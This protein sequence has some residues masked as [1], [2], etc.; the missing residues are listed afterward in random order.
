MTLRISTPALRT[1]LALTALCA[2]PAL[3]AASPATSDT[4]TAAPAAASMFSAS[5]S[6]ADVTREFRYQPAGVSSSSDDLDAADPAA[7]LNEDSGAGQPPPGRRRTYGRSRYQDRMHNADGSSKIAFMAGAGMNI[8]NGN[9]A[10]FYTPSYTF[11]VG[12]GLNFNRMFGVLAEFHYDRMGVTGGAINTEYNNLLNYL[13]QYGYTANDLAGFDANAHVL[14]FT[15]NPVI[16]FADRNSHV[17]AYVT[18]GL[19]Y[20]RKS[21][22]FTLPTAQTGCSYYYCSTY[23]TTYDFDSATANS[24][25]YNVGFGLTYKISEFSNERLFVDARYNWVPIS[26]NNNQDF[27]PYNRRHTSF[28]PVTV[29]IRF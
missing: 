24:I 26:S 23:Y 11:G 20:Y 5:A 9:T 3:Y 25:G 27:F 7:S 10:K 13:S 18:G 22:N 8:P 19:G 17:G 1:G 12:A 14:S 2:A 6:V 4:A 15:V 29:G 21:T 28:I 16:N